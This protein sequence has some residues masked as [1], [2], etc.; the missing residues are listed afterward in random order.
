MNTLFNITAFFSSLPSGP[1]NGVASHGEEE[2]TFL[3]S[4]AVPLKN[5]ETK[6]CYKPQILERQTYLTIGIILYELIIFN[7]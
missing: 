7:S 6:K 5:R 4:V 2:D 1:L 3:V